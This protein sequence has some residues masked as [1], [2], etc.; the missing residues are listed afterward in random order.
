VEDDVHFSRAARIQEDPDTERNALSRHHLSA[1]QHQLPNKDLARKPSD[2]TPRRRTHESAKEQRS[3]LPWEPVRLIIVIYYFLRREQARKA[4]FI[5]VACVAFASIPWTAHLHGLRQGAIVMASLAAAAI[6]MPEL[7]SKLWYLS[8]AEIRDLIPQHRRRAL[9]AELIRAD[10]PKEAWAQEW[11]DLVWRQG[12]TPLLGAAQDTSRIHWNVMYEVSIHL[13][14]KVNV[15]GRAQSMASVETRHVYEC[16]LPDVESGALWV[17]VAGNDASLESEFNEKGCLSRELVRL[18]GLG[19]ESWSDEVRRLCDVHVKIGPNVIRFPADSIVSVSSDDDT[20]IVR[21]L[22]PRI[23]RGP[24]G[25]LVSC[26]IDIGF[27]TKIRENN[28]PLLLA[29]Y[30]CAGT[31][32]LSFKLYHNQ[33]Q[34]PDLH[35][36]GGFISE[37]GSNI[38]AWKPERL[39]TDERQSVVYR[40]PQGSLLWPGS[41]I[42][43]WWESK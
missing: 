1:G 28:F 4:W 16:L 5:F 41:G 7:N 38:A 40:T 22:L 27:P 30:Y 26:Q 9:H 19:Q 24:G 14:V 42:Y 36:F 25:Q 18:P 33:R 43:C 29:G 21:W 3:G 31:T 12:V 32:S 10:C 39:D 15:R 2:R 23:S 6:F 34:R 11:A 35:Y 17:S 37:G 13:G 20:W 8:A